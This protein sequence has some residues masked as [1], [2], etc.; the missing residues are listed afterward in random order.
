M[1]REASGATMRCT[2]AA[3]VLAVAAG[4]E[5]GAGGQLVFADA[6]VVDELVEGRLHHR[7]G[8][9]QLLE[10]DE[11]AAGVVGRRQEFGERPSGCGRFRRARECREDRR[12][13]AG[14]RARRCTRG[15]CPWRRPSAIS[16]FPIPGGPHT[17]QGS[18][19]S[20]RDGES[21]GKLA[22]L[23]RVV[24]G[25]VD[26]VGHWVARACG[27]GAAGSASDP[28]RAPN[29]LV[30]QLPEGRFGQERG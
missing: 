21:G 22:R 14:G 20:R 12:D 10:V 23:Q 3:V 16:L 1:K 2:T 5:G 11:E 26:G 18:W 17:M 28:N 19:A 9:W 15:R 8:G 13:Q 7:E 30:L 25:D 24:G 6:A 27:D 29:R 4:D